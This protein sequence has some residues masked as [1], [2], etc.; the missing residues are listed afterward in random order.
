MG[1]CRNTS[2]EVAYD[3]R[4]LRSI[5]LW[6]HK[7]L[8]AFKTALYEKVEKRFTNEVDK[9]IRKHYAAKSSGV[10]GF[11]VYKEE[12]YF[13]GGKETY[14]RRL[15]GDKKLYVLDKELHSEMDIVIRERREALTIISNHKVL[16]YLEGGISICFSAEDVKKLVPSLLHYVVPNSYFKS[17]VTEDIAAQFKELHSKEYTALEEQLIM[18]MILT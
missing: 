3:I 5:S 18:N 2:T 8:Q 7:C 13:L 17:Q 9:I 10:Q 6:R 15:S 16:S 14:F 12:L 11:I 4:D 1:N